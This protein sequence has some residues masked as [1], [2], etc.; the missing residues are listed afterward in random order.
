MKKTVVII[1]LI[2]VFAL[3]A[4]ADLSSKRI[5]WYYNP[6]CDH[7]RPSAAVE[8]H[9][10]SEYDGFYLGNDEKSVYLTFDLGYE[11]ENVFKILDV[12]KNENVPA[13][14]FLL[15]H[16]VVNGEALTRIIIEGHIAGNHTSHHKDMTKMKDIDTFKEELLSLEED[17][18]RVTG[19]ELKK[20]YRPPSGSFSEENL[21]W[22]KEL[23]YKTIFWS[24][25][26]AD[27]DENA[28]MAP[29]AALN[30]LLSRMHNGA[31]ILLHPTSST[32]AEIL[33]SFIKELKKDGYSFK[34]VD[35]L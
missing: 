26:Y 32:N 30:K 2:F 6:T 7:T 11:N 12:L 27:W 16:T 21:K 34:T 18:K 31:I 20:I 4:S 1:F 13:T 3:S 8:A 22:A 33:S 15:R 5:E 29:E 25:A 28:Q 23:G 14:F 10:L 9:F 24:L 19:K 17:F 35:S